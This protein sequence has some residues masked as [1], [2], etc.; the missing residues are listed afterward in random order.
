MKEDDNG[1]IKQKSRI[2]AFMLSCPQ[3][4]L[5]F[6]FFFCPLTG[7]SL[8]LADTTPSKLN[9]NRALIPH[10]HFIRKDPPKVHTF[11][12]FYGVVV[13]KF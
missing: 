1:N 10:N 13:A 3:L 2:C 6:F 7:L 5:G 11:V 9:S 4:F 12:S 8:R